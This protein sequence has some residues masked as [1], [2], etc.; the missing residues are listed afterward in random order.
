MDKPVKSSGGS[1]GDI[2]M[3][4]NCLMLSDVKKPVTQSK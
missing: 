3:D 1:N 2:G 4:R